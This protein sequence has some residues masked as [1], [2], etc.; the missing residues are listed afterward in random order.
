[1]GSGKNPPRLHLEVYYNEKWGKNPYKTHTLTSV[2]SYITSV[3]LLL[4]PLCFCSF[5]SDM[6]ST[7]LQDSWPGR[8]A[9]NIEVDISQIF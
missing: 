3:V 7:V 5:L 9:G 1:V 8:Q 2:G 6:N 4:L